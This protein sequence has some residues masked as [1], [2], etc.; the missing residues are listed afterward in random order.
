VIVSLTSSEFIVNEG[1]DVVLLFIEKSGVT[2][3]DE[4]TLVVLTL[5]DET[6]QGNT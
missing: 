6:A 3:N 2:P 1:V 4:D 5:S